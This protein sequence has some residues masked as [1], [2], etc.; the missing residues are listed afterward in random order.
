MNHQF[1]E[2]TKGMATSVIRRAALK[3]FGLGLAR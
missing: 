1:D 3:E 2:L